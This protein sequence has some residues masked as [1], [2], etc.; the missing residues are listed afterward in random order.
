M[1]RRTQVISNSFPITRLPTKNYYQ[2]DVTLLFHSPFSDQFTV[3]V[4]PQLFHPRLVY[5]GKAIAYSPG[6]LNL[7]GDSGIAF[8]ISLGRNTQT[9]S[10]ARGSYQLK[11]TLTSSAPIVPEDV[12]D[13]INKGVS[14]TRSAT[15]TNL[16]QLII[17]QGPNHYKS[18]RLINV[19]MDFLNF[20]DVRKLKLSDHDPNFKRLEKFLKKL[21]IKVRTGVNGSKSRIKTI[22]GLIPAAG[23]FIFEKDSEE[24][25]VQQHFY[26]AYGIRIE[27]PGIIGVRLTGKNAPHQDVVPAELCEIEYGQLYR[28]KLPEKFTPEMV[29]FS[30][31]KP[32]IRMQKIM[33]GAIAYNRSEY[34]MESGMTVEPRALTVDAKILSTPKVEYGQ[35]FSLQVANG[36]WNVLGRTFHEPKNLD[37]WAIV[38]F[39]SENIKQHQCEK[40]AYELMNS[41]KS[42]GMRIEKPYDFYSGN[43]YNVL[44][45]LGR[46]MDDIARKAG[47][48]IDR[49]ARTLLIVILPTS[50]A[51]I[52]TLVKHWGDIRHGIKTQCLRENKVV[53]AKNQYWNNVA[54][55]LNARLGGR[56][57]RGISPA[58]QE[59]ERAPFIIMG[60]DVGH[61][62]PGVQKPSVTSLVYSHDVHATQYVAITGIQN[63]REEIIENLRQYAAEAIDSFGAKNRSA[64][65]NIIFF[66]D[67]VSE[68]EY[69]R[70]SQAEIQAI[71]DACTDVWAKRKITDPLPLLTFIVVG[72]R[73]HAVFFPMTPQEGDRIGNLFPGSVIDT[74]IT[75][76]GPANFYLQSHAAIQGTSRSSH[77]IVLEDEIFRDPAT[78]KTDLSK[79]QNLAYTLCHV[80][81]KATRSVSIPA[82]VYYADLVCSR[83]AFHMDPDARLDFDEGMSVSSGHTTFDLSKWQTAFYKT[84]AATDKTMYF[85]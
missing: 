66:R 82:P 6:L 7:G 36:A 48:N 70:V 84:N 8:N 18:G 41:C 19:A 63:P 53:S 55:K 47:G 5:D 32:Q 24:T 85:L 58:M 4:A 43:G 45:D 80:Y 65:K 59:L 42:L 74:G 49:I 33:D 30:T 62:G 51:H 13:I 22:R 28:Q 31:M 9:P 83:G 38:N 10:G 40:M 60:A 2:Y 77:Y 11:L 72:K 37:S 78:K 61:P 23:E 76:P 73:H 81:A 69:E 3:T 57:S 29:Q 16:L 68:G 54:L 26:K 46:A 25:S 79:I 21:R 27:H 44:N 35:N 56:N 1:S 14:S 34:I 20:Q 75:H 39:C 50:A 17:R 52:R 71:R 64:P 12:H 67:G 15:A